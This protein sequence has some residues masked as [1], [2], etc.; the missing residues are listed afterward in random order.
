MIQMKRI[1]IFAV[2]LSFTFV[3][4]SVQAAPGDA[5]TPQ[6]GK[7]AAQ[8]G[9]DNNAPTGPK[10]F[11]LRY[12]EDFSYLD[13]G[14][15]G[16]FFDPIKNIHLNDDWRL[17]LG[18][19]FRF[20][21][22]SETNKAF[23]ATEPA[24][25]AFAHVRLML[26]ADLKYRDMFRIFA[27]G[28]HAFD[29][30]RDLAPRGI[31]ENYFDI[32]QLFIDF[33]VSF[34]DRNWTLRTGRQDLQYGNQ[35]LIS[36]LDWASTRRRFEGFKVF[37]TGDLWDV[38]VFV[39]RPVAVQREQSDHSDED[40]IFGGLYTRYKGIPG[41]G[42]ELYLLGL[43]DISSRV[44]PN[45]DAG[46]L[47]IYTAGAR[48]WGKHGQFDMETEIAGQWGNWAGDTIQ[49]WNFTLNGGY[50]FADINCKPRVGI[51]FDYASGDDDPR[52]GYVQTFN[53]HFPLGHKYFGWLDLIGRQNIVDLNV[54][55][56]AW[57]IS[58]KVKAK[59][60]YHA[61]WLA[62]ERDALYNAGG[63]V[64]R[65]DATGRSGKEVG[66]EL[67]LSMLWKIDVHSNLLV[68]YSHFW[69]G[70]FIHHTGVSE[71]ADLFY[72]QYGFKF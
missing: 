45:F 57:A 28:V 55:L 19:E 70:Q 48:L 47:T 20:R 54:N 35:R 6:V 58:N 72:V 15:G 44:N 23:G 8:A 53:Q 21:F 42:L 51:G 10:Y 12:N 32:Q 59:M 31:D 4:A 26:H 5:Q 34:L 37:S 3:A 62:E 52:D 36:P 13:S 64:S 24:Q 9:Q 39:V 30:E 69:D 49:A 29:E 33:P 14:G 67:D 11:N 60:A 68:G 66:S 46:D 16:D 63:G 1:N 18:G 43:E 25:D 17:S 71:D 38:D 61:F 50:S 7:Q 22:E 41:H 65:R 2:C 56:S 27:Q 40:V